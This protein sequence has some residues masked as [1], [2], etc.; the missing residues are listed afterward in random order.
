MIRG[1]GGESNQS[2]R[3]GVAVPVR[4]ATLAKTIARGLANEGRLGDAAERFVRGVLVGVALDGA[5]VVAVAPVAAAGLRRLIGVRAVSGRRL[6]R[7]HG[8]SRRRAAVRLSRS[9]DQGE[10]EGTEHNQ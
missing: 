3:D 2:R 4:T 8:G 9:R 10:S 1:A 5:A 6:L 7:C